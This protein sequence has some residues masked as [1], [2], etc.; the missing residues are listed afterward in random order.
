MRA[1][2]HSFTLTNRSSRRWRRHRVVRAHRRRHCSKM[3]S[4]RRR[5]CPGA[6]APCRWRRARRRRIACRRALACLVT[7]CSYG[8]SMHTYPHHTHTS[9]PDR[10]VLTRHAHGIR[11]ALAA[12][13]ALAIVGA[14]LLGRHRLVQRARAAAAAAA[15]VVA[16][17][18]C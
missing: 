10:L 9:T 12:A 6:A 8:I 15:A 3:H 17:V 2:V 18:L 1:R 4:V 11:P 14:H 13:A 5:A 7:I 16:A